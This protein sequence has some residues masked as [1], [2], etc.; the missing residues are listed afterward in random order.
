MKLLNTDRLKAYLQSTGTVSGKVDRTELKS[1]VK[2]QINTAPC[3]IEKRV[4]SA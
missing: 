3:A 4:S 2:Y 1:L